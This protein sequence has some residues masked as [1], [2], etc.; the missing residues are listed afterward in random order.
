MVRQRGRWEIATGQ[1]GR[2][3]NFPSL[4]LILFAVPVRFAVRVA[5]VHVLAVGTRV[6]ESLQTLAALE[7]FL[8]AVQ[9]LVLCEMVFVLEGLWTLDAFVGALACRR[10]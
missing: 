6:R 5:V 3:R 9:S 2:G 4:V 1:T 7:W 8:A 10:R